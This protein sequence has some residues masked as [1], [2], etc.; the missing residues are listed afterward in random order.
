MMKINLI[1]LDKSQENFYSFQSSLLTNK[2]IN[3]I[4]D[5]SVKSKNLLKVAK[6]IK[7]EI[8]SNLKKI[9]LTNNYKKLFN[10]T[11][12]KIKHHLFDLY[13]KKI[14]CDDQLLY[15]LLKL[16]SKYNEKYEIQFLIRALL[17]NFRSEIYFKVILYNYIFRVLYCNYGVYNDFKYFHLPRYIKKFKNF[18]KQNKKNFGNYYYDSGR[19]LTGPDLVPNLF[20]RRKYDYQYKNGQDYFYTIKNLRKDLNTNKLTHI[21]SKCRFIDKHKREYDFRDENDLIFIDYYH[22]KIRENYI[23]TYK[24]ANEFFLYK[25]TKSIFEKKGIKILREYSP[26]LLKPQRIDIYFEYNKKKIAFEYQG[27]QHFK[28]ISFFGGK[29]AYDKRKKLDLKKE[30]ICKK[31]N[32]KLI[33]FNYF[34]P[35]SIEAVIN[36]LKKNNIKID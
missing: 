24:W 5:K 8:V 33:K 28:P 6:N 27:E 19:I 12:R 21:L 36:K 11:S 1:L 3:K 35:I 26:K 17:D 34:E 7:K 4:I 14:K 25:N 29:I 23:G 13:F 32:I 18:Y 10:S 15:F 30:R 2:K 31:L 20:G 9:N 16:N 22:Q